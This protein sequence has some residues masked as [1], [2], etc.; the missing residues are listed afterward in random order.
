MSPE[1]SRTNHKPEYWPFLYPINENAVVLKARRIQ[2]THQPAQTA[3]A[4]ALIDNTAETLT[5]LEDTPDCKERQE[6]LSGYIRTLASIAVA[7]ID[8]EE[9]VNSK[10]EE[11]LGTRLKP[12]FDDDL[13]S[14]ALS[15]PE[16]IGRQLAINTTIAC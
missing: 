16:K 1:Q 11:E 8:W 15:E 6:S 7:N 9:K 14:E 4:E 2:N 13:E 5:K 10:L 12:Y 3:I